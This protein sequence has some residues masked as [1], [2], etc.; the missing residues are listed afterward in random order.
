MHSQRQNELTKDLESLQEKLREAKQATKENERTKNFEEAIATLKRLYPGV[1][2]RVVDLV[3]P[4]KAY[5]VAV[6]VAL[7]NNMDAVIVDDEK[8]AIDCIQV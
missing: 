4:S 7:G 3:Q 6:T 8:T 5:K 2:G 1:H